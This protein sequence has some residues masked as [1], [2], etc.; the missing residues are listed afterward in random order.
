MTSALRPV[1]APYERTATCTT[2]LWFVIVPAEL[3]D[4]RVNLEHLH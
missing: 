4:G 2:P 3:R 1:S